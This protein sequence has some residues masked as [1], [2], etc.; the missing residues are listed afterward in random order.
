MGN[1]VTTSTTIQQMHSSQQEHSELQGL[2]RFMLA[3]KDAHTLYQQ[4]GFKQLDDAD[5]IMQI[6]NP[7]VYQK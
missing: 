1:L 3:T 5:R 4:F 2:R 6:R 7:N